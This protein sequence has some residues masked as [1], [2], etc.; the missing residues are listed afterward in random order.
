MRNRTASDNSFENMT[1]SNTFNISPYV[2]IPL[3]S[4]LSTRAGYLFTN[5]WYDDTS[6]NNSDT[7]S[8]FVSLNNRFPFG[9]D[10]S[11]KYDYLAYRPEI[12]DDSDIQQ[13]FVIANYQVGPKLR[14]WIGGGMSYV[15]FS[16][17][18]NE[19]ESIWNVGCEYNLSI[20]G[21]TMLS[22]TYNESLSANEDIISNNPETR[23][24]SD[25]RPTVFHNN[26][27]ITT[28]VTNDKRLDLTLSTS[29]YIDL[30]INP[31]YSDQK[32]IEAERKDKI[33][34]VSANLSKS[35]TSKIDISI[36][37]FWEKQKFSPQDTKVH[38]YS[39]GTSLEYILSRHI[40]ANIGYRYNKRNSDIS[41]D[42]YDNNIVWL[43]TK[44]SF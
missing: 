2:D 29:K 13:V 42:D 15:D 4:T 27:S 5:I 37:G 31:Y 9:L 16:N 40:T 17:R 25:S 44:L 14:V 41:N 1:E 32:E 8:A 23:A 39:V 22:A 18:S 12:T 30:T 35:L 21:G 43:Q 26:D 3:T 11:I 7:H 38:V 20:L 33:Y 10:V 6:G 19:E 28:G 34:G 24:I 36:D